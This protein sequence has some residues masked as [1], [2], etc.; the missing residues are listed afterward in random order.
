MTD[1]ETL[2]WSRLRGGKLDGRKFTKQ[3]P[4][5]P[6]VA[7]FACRSPKLVVE[8]DGG[9]HSDAAEADAARTR[10]IESYGYT[11]IRFWNSE[12]TENLDGVLEEILRTLRIASAE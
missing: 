1:S 10:T 12:V 7:D 4:I 9:Q 5:G 2:L 6:H 11:V 3:F 8:L